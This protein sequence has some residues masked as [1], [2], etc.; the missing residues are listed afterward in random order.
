MASGKLPKPTRF[1][2]FS[3]SPSLLRIDLALLL[4]SLRSLFFVNIFTLSNH[5]TFN[6]RSC[7]RC[8]LATKWRGGCHIGS[9]FADNSIISGT[10][11]CGDWAAND[12]VYP[13]Q[14]SITVPNAPAWESCVQQV[15][16]NPSAYSDGYWEVNFIKIFGEVTTPPPSSS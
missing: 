1:F 4:Q 7:C 14:C 11:F 3:L 16:N 8:F 10:N 5:D 9:Y 12:G 2:H 15:A 6:P 13:T